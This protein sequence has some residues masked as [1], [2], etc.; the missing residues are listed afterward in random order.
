[1][2]SNKKPS[3][4]YWMFSRFGWVK[5][6]FLF[7]LY[8]GWIVFGMMWMMIATTPASSI[9]PSALGIAMLFKDNTM[10]SNIVVVCWFFLGTYVYWW[11]EV[12]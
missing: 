4:L 6:V 5:E 12:D 11:R 10:L 1:M 2:Y 7:I 8:Y 9:S 3:Y